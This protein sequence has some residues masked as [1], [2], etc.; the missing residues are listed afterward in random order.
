MAPIKVTTI[1]RLELM[2]ALLSAEAAEFLEAELMGDIDHRFWTDSKIVLGYVKN[3]ARR[4]HTFVSNRVQQ[5]R[6]ASSPDQWKFVR[7]RDN[8][9][10]L[11][12]RG[13]TVAQLLESE[14]WWKG[15][16]FLWSDVVCTGEETDSSLS[17]SDPE[18]KQFDV[19]CTH[20]EEVWNI[21]E[22]LAKFSS[23][24]SAL[25]AFAW[26][27]RHQ[28]RYSQSRSCQSAQ[29]E[30]HSTRR[31][32]L[33]EIKMAETEII[34][35]TQRLHYKELYKS[36]GSHPPSNINRLIRLDPFIDENGL[37]RVGGRIKYS[38]F[39]GH[40][41]HPIIVPKFSELAR[42]IIS[43]CH[44][45]V[46]HQGRGFTLGEIRSRGYWIV[47]GTSAV[48][49]YIFKCVLCRKLRGSNVDQKMSELPNDR[50]ACEPAFT[51]CGVDIFG[52]FY[53]REGRS[54]KKRYGV[55]FTCM[56][57]RAVHIEIAVSLTTDSFINAFRRFVAR[58]GPVSTLRSD[59]GTNF[60]GAYN[61]LFQD[62]AIRALRELDCQWLF[63]PPHASHMGGSWERQIRSV[64]SILQSLMS[65]HGRQL[66]DETLHTFMVEAE[67]IMNG[68]PLC[69]DDLGTET[70]E[71]LTPNLLLTGKVKVVLPPPVEFQ[72]GDVY[73]RKLWKR[74]QY[75]VDEFWNRW[76]K[77][78]LCNLQSR[79]KWHKPR[80]NLSEGDIVVVADA[81]TPR[82]QWQL[83][84]IS[85]TFPDKDG[86]VRKVKITLGDS[87]LDSK[88]R[89][90]RE[91]VV[92]E[93]PVH[94]LVL[95]LSE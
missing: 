32:N 84:R 72:R 14:I 59:R 66:N 43:H 52:P 90:R 27:L 73:S 57:S 34:R 37:L 47:Q 8:P 83:A 28:N 17:A 7:T 16:S 65:Q 58:R 56:A 26:I 48:S 9:A 64:R 11:T 79:S 46:K 49:S 80:T 91:L 5:I 88:G 87:S 95:L 29:R 20:S 51:H 55:L 63:N 3:D 19:C 44:A 68:R 78:F 38:D 53:V 50:L 85:E 4:F 1:P 86:L 2:A 39:P 74:V 36:G 23:W 71:P 15:P 24:Q 70:P 92:W 76:R 61:E 41:K 10:D 77:S 21:D 81:Q 40:L 54:D 33:T 42:L 12:S 25:V 18:V 67:S 35:Q 93:R 75:L 82:N 62:N 13:A 94:S 6:N 89:R 30:V 22:R 31:V 69:A 45:T 60:V